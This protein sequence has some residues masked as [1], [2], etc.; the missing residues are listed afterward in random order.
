MQDLID[1][2]AENY[3]SAGKIV[4]VGVGR[5]REVLEELAERL[6]AVVVGVDSRE[7]EGLVKD[8]IFKPEYRIY[9]G[10]ELIYALRPEPEL[11]PALKRIAHEVGSDLI[12]K[13]FSADPSLDLEGLELVNYKGECFYIKR[14]QK[15]WK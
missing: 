5:Q 1:Y 4:E 9:R 8:D 7:I 11:Y 3:L 12:V 2:I 14:H 6:N 10:A 15:Q 13:P